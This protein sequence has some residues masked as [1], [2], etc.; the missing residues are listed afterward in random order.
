[1]TMEL[2]NQSEYRVYVQQYAN[3]KKELFIFQNK[4]NAMKLYNEASEANYYTH[5]EYY[6]DGKFQYNV[7]G[8][9]KQ[10][11]IHNPITI[12]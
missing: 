11:Y 7:C 5:I 10:E 1:M 2:T 12:L 6:L 4:E 8:S 3:S 9:C